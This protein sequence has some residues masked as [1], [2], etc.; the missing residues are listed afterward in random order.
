MPANQE[1][2]K[3]R[4]RLNQLSKVPSLIKPKTPDMGVMKDFLPK[5]SSEQLVDYLGISDESEQND[6]R[7]NTESYFQKNSSAK[8]RLES[9]YNQAEKGDF[10]PDVDDN[11]NIFLRALSAGFGVT[12]KALSPVF[13]ALKWYDTNVADPT[14]GGASLL[15]AALLP[16]EQ[17]IETIMRRK[18]DEGQGIWDSLGETFE[19]FGAPG[20]VKFGIQLA[21]DPLVFA[22]GVNLIRKGA[23]TA[24]NTARLLDPGLELGYKGSRAVVNKLH[25][26]IPQTKVL[27]H[28]ARSG[29]D[30]TSFVNES[31]DLVLK[32]SHNFDGRQVG[33]SLTDNVDVAKDYASRVIDPFSGTGTPSRSQG[34][35][36]FKIDEDALP[37]NVINMETDSEKFLQGAE[38]IIIPKG[39]FQV[40]GDNKAQEAL[41]DW[42]NT[43]IKRSR[44]LSSDEL[45]REFSLQWNGRVNR[46]FTHGFEDPM[47]GYGRPSDG[48]SSDIV[49]KYGL[50]MPDIFAHGPEIEARMRENPLEMSAAIERSFS[51]NLKCL[52]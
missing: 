2:S 48:L 35:F 3:A 45:A 30:L 34:G 50:D 5:L 49:S 33:V 6:L 32:A 14:A 28:G 16:G 37:K 39:K 20:W 7:T 23:V 42:E 10:K 41:S 36:V 22:G 21:A 12:G 24:A 11:S 26:R 31:G 44:S 18:L 17:E 19:E 40:F 52:L 27:Y 13:E 1:Y 46:E 8:A 43:Q 29:S 15:I 38:D 51:W 25:T 9:M 4:E 47:G